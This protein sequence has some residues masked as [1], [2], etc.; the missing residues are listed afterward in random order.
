MRLWQKQNQIFVKEL[1]RLSLPSL[2]VGYEELCF[3]PEATMAAVADFLDVPPDR[4]ML[5][6]CPSGGHVAA[7]NPM[8]LDPQKSSRLTYDHRWFFSPAA[9]A[10]Y[11]MLPGV[12]RLNE[13]LVYPRSRAGDGS[14]SFRPPTAVGFGKPA[15]QDATQNPTQID[16]QDTPPQAAGILTAP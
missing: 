10:A 14:D 5:A 9:S 7:G 12:R 2:N 6:P 3:F 13:R 16:T 11:H 15:P 8:R 1:D 4:G